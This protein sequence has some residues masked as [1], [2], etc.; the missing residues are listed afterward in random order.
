MLWRGYPL[1]EATW[2]PIEHMDGALDLVIEFNEG[3]GA[4]LQTITASVPQSAWARPP[5]ISTSPTRAA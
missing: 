1:S 2:E 5:R 3:R 4:A